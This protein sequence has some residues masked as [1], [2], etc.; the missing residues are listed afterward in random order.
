M[1]SGG[2]T[3]VDANPLAPAANITRAGTW[4]G[5]IFLEGG[6]QKSRGFFLLNNLPA[7][8]GETKD[9]TDTMSGKVVLQ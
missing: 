2:F 5:G 9:N 1:V 3:M 8:P 6:V 7:V 4:F